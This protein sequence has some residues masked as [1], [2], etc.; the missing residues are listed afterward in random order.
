MIGTLVVD[1][2]SKV[3]SRIC[4]EHIKEVHN[5]IRLRLYQSVH[6]TLLKIVSKKASITSLD[7][8]LLKSILSR[9]DVTSR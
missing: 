2:L 1:W 6:Q 7:K 3:N 9:F 5:M 4:T 8:M